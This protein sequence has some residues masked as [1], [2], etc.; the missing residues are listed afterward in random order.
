MNNR[1][2][3]LVKF[4]KGITDNDNLPQP[5]QEL[6]TK[7]IQEAEIK[8]SVNLLYDEGTNETTTFTQILQNK[9]HFL[10]LPILYKLKD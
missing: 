8:M 1:K 7:D 5:C 6:Q 10:H 2:V 4:F 9:I 3:L